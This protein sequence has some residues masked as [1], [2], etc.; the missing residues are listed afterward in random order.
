MTDNRIY[1]VIINTDKQWFYG[2]FSNRKNMLDSLKANIDLQGAYIQGVT[3]KLD[4]TPVTI[5]NGFVESGL[6]IYK[7]DVNGNKK[8]FIKVLMHQMNH[9]SPY[10]T[11]NKKQ[12]KLF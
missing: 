8:W 5:F 6:T 3:K 9:V 10:F 12:T 4:I 2:T 7:D 1:S 11:V